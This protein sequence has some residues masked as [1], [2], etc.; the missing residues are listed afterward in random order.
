MQKRIE[1]PTKKWIETVE[2]LQ[3]SMQGKERRETPNKIK[4]FSACINIVFMD[5]ITL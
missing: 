3:A 1:G 2:D 4:A 5:K